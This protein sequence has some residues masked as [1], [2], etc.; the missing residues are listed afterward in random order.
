MRILVADALARGKGVR[1][2]TVD[3][4]GSGP[5]AVA[6]LLEARGIHA[7]IV[8]YEKL[9][10]S[11]RIIMDYDAVFVSIMSTDVEA[12]VRLLREKVSRDIPYVVGGP[13]ALSYEYLLRKG[14]DLA[15]I[16][17]AEEVIDAVIDFLVDRDIDKISRTPGIA[18]HEL[19]DKIVYTG[20]AH[21]PTREKLNY[22]HATKS[23]KT[24]S[25]YLF[26]RVYVEIVRG[27]SNFR[28][29]RLPLP[30]GRKCIE[31]NLCWT[32]PLALRMN[33]PLN[34]PAGC[35]YCSVPSLFGPARSRDVEIIVREIRELVDIGVKRITLSAPD[36][37]DYGRDFLVEP[38]PLTDPE[39]PPPNREA[40]ERLFRSIDARVPEWSSGEVVI[41][42][43]NIKANLVDEDT[44]RLLGEYFKDTPV[45]VGVE[46]G[47][48]KHAISIG[49]PVSPR[50][51]VDAIR[52]LSKY[53]LRPYVYF[54][55]GLPGETRE[56]IVR[57]IK[58]M[59]KLVAA[60]AE[61]ITA[62]RFTPLPGTAFED[63]NIPR[64]KGRHPILL[65][66]KNL[67]KV[68]K[69]RL[70]GLRIKGVVGGYYRSRKLSG[71]VVY[72]FHHGPVIIARSKHVLEKGSV[73]EVVIDE[74]ISDRLVAG[75]IVSLRE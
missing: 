46:T 49:R 43:E 56:T 68:V 48:E 35:G 75:T 17:E 51:V 72:P 21:H 29:T 74:I 33:C 67:N 24:H 14:Y 2:V 41:L 58:L 3:V 61:K 1:R 69:K 50:R 8:D 62:Y 6:G 57:S 59:H 30:D 45:H 52:L 55:Y 19:G 54:I 70:L 23:I 53:G 66:S 44:A 13:G 63:F 27:C 37:L 20:L 42:L 31:C 16:G 5:R 34:I 12:A 10:A 32:G 4:I 60:G 11:P 64:T 25:Y 18:Y 47:D 15:V 7:N 40:L 73:I 65:E 71:V 38:E 28:R 26:A 22:K 39:Y 36:I 9:L